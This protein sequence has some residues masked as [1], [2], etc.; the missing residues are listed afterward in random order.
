MG[1]QR[2]HS[3]EL[4]LC[5]PSDRTTMTRFPCISGSDTT[6][7]PTLGRYLHDG[8]VSRYSLYTGVP[9]TRFDHD[10]DAICPCYPSQAPFYSP[11]YPKIIMQ[12]SYTFTSVKPLHKCT[13]RDLMDFLYK[14]DQYPEIVNEVRSRLASYEAMP[15]KNG[16]IQR[17]IKDIKYS[18]E[19]YNIS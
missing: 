3:Y 8:A 10:H 2:W 19:K 5:L 14:P 13:T 4:Y 11:R 7:H 6:C 12:S 1:H 17:L 15:K 16:S 18:F 9:G